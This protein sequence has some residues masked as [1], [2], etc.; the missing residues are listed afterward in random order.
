LQEANRYKALLRYLHIKDIDRAVLD[1]VHRQQLDFNQAVKAGVFTPIG[2][3]CLDFPGFFA[4]IA[5]NGY[6]GWCVV[7]QDIEFGG[8]V[9]PKESMAASLRHLDGVSASVA[10]SLS[11]RSTPTN[12][13]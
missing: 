9:V 12:A 5:A 8:P 6:R 3:G 2:D 1:Q 13:D 11:R 7:E 4:G 10:A